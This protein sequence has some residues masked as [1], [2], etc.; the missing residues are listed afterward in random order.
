MKSKSGYATSSGPFIGMIPITVYLTG[1]GPGGATGAYPYTCQVPLTAWAVNQLFIKD[2]STDTAWLTFLYTWLKNSMAFH[3][4]IDNDGTNVYGL[5]AYDTS[6]LASDAGVWISRSRADDD[7][8]TNDS[9]WITTELIPSQTQYWRTT[10]CDPERS[11]AIAMGYDAMANIATA[12][13]HSSDATTYTAQAAAIRAAIKSLM[14]DEVQKRFQWVERGDEF[15]VIGSSGVAVAGNSTITVTAD[16]LM[17]LPAGCKVTIANVVCQPITA[18]ELQAGVPTV[19]TVTSPLTGNASGGARYRNFAEVDNC[20]MQAAPLW[21]QC[22]TNAQA[23]SVASRLTAV[24]DGITPT[25]WEC[26]FGSTLR[27]NIAQRTPWVQWVVYQNAAH[28]TA[29]PTELVIA[30]GNIGLRIGYRRTDSGNIMPALGLNAT[31]NGLQYLHTPWEQVNAAHP[32]TVTVTWRRNGAVA[33][34]ITVQDFNLST[35]ATVT[36]AVPAGTDGQP[37]SATVT[38]TT[39][40]MPGVV[41]IS[42]GNGDVAIKYVKITTVPK[43][44]TYLSP[45]GGLL[46]TH[47]FSRVAMFKPA[48]RSMEYSNA[49][50]MALDYWNGDAWPPQNFWAIVGLNNYGLAAGKTIGSEYARRMLLEAQA[51]T[52]YVGPSQGVWERSSANG[53]MT[54]SANYCWGSLLWA[55]G[56]DLGYIPLT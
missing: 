17:W 33:P 19:V 35:V 30:N 50:W 1:Q 12:L 21:A 9:Y 55:A 29:N 49:T 25:A 32:L 24:L 8:T 10:F 47:R 28:L 4:N 48:I 39:A 46:S 52:A 31:Y 7:G 14:W 27:N 11:S 23:A 54:G 43:G 38:V 3:E 13:G 42:A 2:G 15:H 18:Y 41:E 34:T 26:W 37:V 56:I 36:P 22:A 45:Q 51:W 6:G 16:N 40:H 5:S 53:F 20:G 44:W